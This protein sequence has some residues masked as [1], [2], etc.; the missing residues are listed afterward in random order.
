MMTMLLMMVQIVR[1]AVLGTP[2][3]V[4]TTLLQW[5][6]VQQ[7]S[8]LKRQADAAPLATRTHKTNHISS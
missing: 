5:S 7:R 8:Q 4:V 1:V 6:F 3:M 2:V